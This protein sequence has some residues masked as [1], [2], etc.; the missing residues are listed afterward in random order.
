MNSSVGLF[1]AKHVAEHT[2]PREALQHLKQIDR[3]LPGK[4]YIAFYL[5]L[6][7]LNL[8]EARQAGDCFQRALDLEPVPQDIASI[9]SYMGV[10]LKELGD[11]RTA[12]EVLRRGCRYDAERTDLYNLL[13]FCHFKLKEHAAAIENF[14][15]VIRLNPAS[16][17]DYANIGVNYRE[18]GQREKAIR[19][20]KRAVSLDPGI[21]FARRSLEQLQ[22]ESPASD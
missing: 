21:E 10:A 7:H 22:A 1:A 20:F 14:K 3:M 12:L 8:G 5:G 18:L 4:Y 13:G 15:T 16:A 6:A 19:Y 17:I 9:Y 2:P 11:Y